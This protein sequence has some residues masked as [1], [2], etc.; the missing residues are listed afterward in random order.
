MIGQYIGPR[1]ISEIKPYNEK[2]S[3]VIFED[4]HQE[5]FANTILAVL[6]QDVAYDLTTLRDKRVDA[7]A[8]KILEVLRDANCK[9]GEL[10]YL[11]GK[12]Q[13]SV[14]ESYGKAET[15]L[16]GTDAKGILDLDRVLLGDKKTLDDILKSGV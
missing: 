9:I 12:V 3:L 13:L 6:A 4:G 10:Q 15:I 5:I 1:K 14:E 16:W 11:F 8:E 7:I 2:A